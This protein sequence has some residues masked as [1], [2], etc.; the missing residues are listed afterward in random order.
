MSVRTKIFHAELRRI[1]A[2]PGEIRLE[3]STVG[4]CLAD[5]VRRYPEAEPLMFDNHGRLRRQF[6][7][8]VNQE[9]MFKAEFSRPVTEND[10]LILVVL[11]SGG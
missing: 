1:I 11:A 6:Y 9:S 10:T 7:V 3:G 5:L 4:E 8:Y 2:E